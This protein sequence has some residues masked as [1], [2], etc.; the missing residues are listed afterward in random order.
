[1]LP[2]VVIVT[3]ETLRRAPHSHREAGYALGVSKAKIT[4]NI[5]L[6]TAKSG[7]LTGIGLGIVRIAGE[8]APLMVTN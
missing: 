5:V 1:M 4:L 6:M 7:V 8:T 2:I 3:E